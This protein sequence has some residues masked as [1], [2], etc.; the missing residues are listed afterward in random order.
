MGC[1]YQVS[2]LDRR[3]E[4]GADGKPESHKYTLL[5]GEE[6]KF[7]PNMTSDADRMTIRKNWDMLMPLGSGTVEIADWESHPML[8]KPITDDPIRNGSIY[9]A[10]WTHALHCVGSPVP[11]LLA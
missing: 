9:E 6:E 11:F 10:S 7:F 4:G 2:L 1:T 8:G 3:Q 5:K